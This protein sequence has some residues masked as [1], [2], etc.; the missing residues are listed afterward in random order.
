MTLNRKIKS[1]KAFYPHVYP[2]LVEKSVLVFNSF[3]LLLW[4]GD[5]DDENECIEQQ[6][7]LLGFCIAISMLEKKDEEFFNIRFL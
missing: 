6:R 1:W 2:V 4:S 7:R 5:D 3:S